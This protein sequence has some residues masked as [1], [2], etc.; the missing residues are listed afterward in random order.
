MV[1]VTL[2]KV[3]RRACCRG[4]QRSGGGGGVGRCPFAGTRGNRSRC[5]FSRTQCPVEYTRIP[6]EDPTL[7][8][9]YTN[10]HPQGIAW[11]GVQSAKTHVDMQAQTG[12]PAVEYVNLS[13]V[14]P[15]SN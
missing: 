8:T 7:T 4:N 2:C 5:P 6:E 3:F 11:G 14:P 9:S 10:T 15:P 13:Y 1:L 12:E